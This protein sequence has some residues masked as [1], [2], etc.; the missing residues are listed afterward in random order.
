[1]CITLQEMIDSEMHFRHT[2][3]QTLGKF[4]LCTLCTFFFFFFTT[5]VHQS[6]S[7]HTLY[8]EKYFI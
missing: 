8:T 1:M 4:C 6:Y 3:K 7:M 2:M 5:S